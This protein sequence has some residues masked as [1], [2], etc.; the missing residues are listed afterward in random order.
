MAHTLSKL[1]ASKRRLTF[2][3]LMTSR[4]GL[5]PAS[6]RFWR[7]SLSLERQLESRYSTRDMSTMT[8]GALNVGASIFKKSL[9]VEIS[10]SFWSHV[11]TSG[12]W[13]GR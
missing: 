12:S 11:T 6:L 5:N 8:L 1:V 13:I 9:H 3:A 4:A 7:M 2:I 10:Y